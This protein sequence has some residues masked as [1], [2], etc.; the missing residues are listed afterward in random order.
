MGLNRQERKIWSI[1]ECDS[2]SDNGLNS[3]R[4]VRLARRCLPSATDY[5]Y[6]CCHI[7]DDWY[8]N[9]EFLEKS[10]GCFFSSGSSSKETERR[11]REGIL[12][13]L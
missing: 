3:G 5:S 8:E 6:L 2:A 12:L 10:R 4:I 7:I 9:E 13:K 11:G 1:M